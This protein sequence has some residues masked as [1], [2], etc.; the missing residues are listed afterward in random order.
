MLKG[1]M[2]NKSGLQVPGSN[3]KPRNYVILRLNAFLSDGANRFD[4]EPNILTIEHV[5]PQKVES[6]SEWE[7]LWPDTD[8]REKWLNRISNLIPLT[9]KKNSSAQN[10][11]FEKK[12]KVYFSPAFG[13]TTWPLATRV[14]WEKEW[15]PEVLER[16]QEELL[17]FFSDLWD[18]E[19]AITKENKQFQ[20]SSDGAFMETEALR[21]ADNQQGKK[22]LS[23]K[24]TGKQIEQ[25]IDADVFS[26]LQ[27][28]GRGKDKIV[29]PL[30]DEWK[31]EYDEVLNFSKYTVSSKYYWL[32]PSKDVLS[33]DWTVVLFNTD[34]LMMTVMRIPKD[35]LTVES[36]EGFKIRNDSSKQGVLK[37]EFL[38]NSFI[39]KH[40]KINFTEYITNVIKVTVA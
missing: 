12:K 2:N 38:D 4:S 31:I 6:G 25:S 7:R 39:E 20:N 14:I 5:L 11:D 24:A 32:E 27:A 36:G 8:I 37:L 9:R 18:L 15:T 10:Y 33:K 3:N 26:K 23:R 17:G 34:T 28:G 21:G 22:P 13:V 19:Y 16:R 29:K 30:F 1:T 35:T 40:S